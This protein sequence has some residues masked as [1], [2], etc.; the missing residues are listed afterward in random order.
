M[1]FVVIVL[2]IL[3][4]WGIYKS[5]ILFDMPNHGTLPTILLIVSIC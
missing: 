2:P 3:A 4:V 1:L 5:I